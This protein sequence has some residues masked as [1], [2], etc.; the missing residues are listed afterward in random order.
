[1]PVLRVVNLDR[2]KPE[3]CYLQERRRDINSQ[4]G[5]DGVIEAIFE[6]VPPANRW[7]VEFGAWDG[8]YLSNTCHLVRDLGWHGV[9]IEGSAEKYADLRANYD[10]LAHA[11]PIHALVGFERGVDSLDDVLAGTDC[12]RDVDL[13]S[14]DIDGADYHVWRSLARYRPRVVMIEF[15]PSVPN[16][17]VFVQDRDMAVH[18]GASLAA[19]VELGKQKRYELVATTNC[20]AFFVRE[21]LFGAFGIDDNS[22]DAMHPNV[23]GRIFHGYDGT[24]YTKMRP[25]QWAGRGGPRPEI[26]QF[27]LL[28]PEARNFYDHVDSA[29]GQADVD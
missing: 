28:P 16:D 4:F 1:M 13:V 6:I 26:D 18:Q 12:P 7:C 14:I 5:E 3:S 9:L 15:N 29:P 25:L 22:V 24:I 19:L 21:E 27:Q 2:R 11:H 17:V 23:I 20:N 10:G 8:V